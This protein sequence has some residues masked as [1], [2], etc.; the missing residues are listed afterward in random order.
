[1]EPSAAPRRGRLTQRG[2]DEVT[3]AGSDVVKR[4]VY[5][6]KLLIILLFHVSGE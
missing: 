5:Y 1:M 4:L 2:G 3:R 6:K